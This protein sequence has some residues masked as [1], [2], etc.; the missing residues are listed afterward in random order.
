MSGLAAADSWI[1]FILSRMTHHLCRGTARAP[2]GTAQVFTSHTVLFGDGIS[3][4]KI[5]SRLAQ[6]VDAPDGKEK[7]PNKAQYRN[8]EWFFIDG[9]RIRGQ[10]ECGAIEKVRRD[11][12]QNGS[13]GA[14]RGVQRS[15]MS[16]PRQLHPSDDLC[17]CHLCANGTAPKRRM[18]KAGREAVAESVLPTSRRSRKTSTDVVLRQWNQ[19]HLSFFD[20]S[21][22]L[23]RNGSPGGERERESMYPKHTRISSRHTPKQVRFR[24]SA[25]TAHVPLRH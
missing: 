1:V 19:K 13:K 2:H 8:G 4:P 3:C 7:V 18:T 23:L 9:I 6:S 17:H 16:N 12:K 10:F 15:D 25:H 22:R 24:H 20:T 14:L 21:I 5:L 11:Q